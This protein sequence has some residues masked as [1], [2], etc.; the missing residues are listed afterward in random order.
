MLK[1]TSSPKM[2]LP[3]DAAVRLRGLVNDSAGAQGSVQGLRGRLH[4]RASLNRRRCICNF[5]A[6]NLAEY[7][8]KR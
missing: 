5:R 4:L 7:R 8:V 2:L 3:S 1:G 6:H